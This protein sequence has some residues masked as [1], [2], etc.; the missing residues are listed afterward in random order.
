M[1]NEKSKRAKQ[2]YVKIKVKIKLENDKRSI[3]MVIKD[4]GY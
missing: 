1:R 2:K 3:K 4:C